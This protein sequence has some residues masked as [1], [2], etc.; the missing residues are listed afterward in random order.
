MENQ[1]YQCPVCL[2]RYPT[3]DL[4]KQCEAWCSTHDICNLEIIKHALP[5]EDDE[6]YEQD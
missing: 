2:L 6:N 5:P 3:Q 4:A 1:S